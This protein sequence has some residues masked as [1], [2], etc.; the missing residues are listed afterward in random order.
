M[1]YI[2]FSV[3]YC[4][5]SRYALVMLL[6]HL[7]TPRHVN[8][9]ADNETQSREQQIYVSQSDQGYTFAIIHGKQP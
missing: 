7:Q 3:F 1:E 4:Q 8:P 5:L 2:I 9:P 6:K